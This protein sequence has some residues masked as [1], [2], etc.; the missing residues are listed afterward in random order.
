MKK[1][2]YGLI[3]GAVLTLWYGTAIIALLLLGKGIVWLIHLQNAYKS[4]TNA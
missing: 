1:I 3:I 4:F 2:R